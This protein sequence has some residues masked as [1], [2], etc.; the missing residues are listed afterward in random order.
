MKLTTLLPLA[1]L[2]L[3]GIDAR[4]VHAQAW[5]IR[6]QWR[7]KARPGDPTS[8][9]FAYEFAGEAVAA[10]GSMT[11]AGDAVKYDCA[12]LAITAV[13]VDSGMAPAPDAAM[14]AGTDAAMSGAMDSGTPARAD[15]GS[16]S[17]EPTSS[18]GCATPA[19]AG[20]QG[21]PAV[22]SLGLL[23]LLAR[24]RRRS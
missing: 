10:A 16:P 12:D 17:P 13:A 5:P 21:L 23:A 20:R 1:A 24:R 7:D 8:G 9:S 15:A 18:C 11:A 6:H 3:L 22:V 14:P 19:D 4:P 2:V